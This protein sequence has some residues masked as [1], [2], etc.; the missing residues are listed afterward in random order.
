MLKETL[1]NKQNYFHNL[2]ETEKQLFD[3]IA[4]DQVTG[5][6]FDLKYA[7][8]LKNFDPDNFHCLLTLMKISTLC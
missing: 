1:K 3:Q 6:T 7:T 5:A 4:S 2:S 8:A